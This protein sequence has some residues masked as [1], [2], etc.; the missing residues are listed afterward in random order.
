M[1]AWV[2][3][4]VIKPERREQLDLKDVT[5]E[6]PDLEIQIWLNIRE[7]VGRTM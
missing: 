6:K 1:R 2:K 5:K 3:L 7:V 4:V